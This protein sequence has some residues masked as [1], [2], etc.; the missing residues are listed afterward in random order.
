MY[1]T[2]DA[3]PTP[4]L[5]TMARS[6]MREV[7]IRWVTFSSALLMLLLSVTSSKKGCTRTPVA[8]PAVLPA[9]AV[10]LLLLLLLLLLHAASTRSIPS[11]VKQP[12]NTTPPPF[13]IAFASSRPKPLSH[14]L[15]KTPSLALSGS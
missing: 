3:L 9:F 10:V 11:F 13:T 1:S 5:F 14:P 12:A 6:R 7:A 2:L 4:A 8:L 15:T